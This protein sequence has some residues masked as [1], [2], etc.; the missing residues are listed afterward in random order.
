MCQINTIIGGIYFGVVRWPLIIVNIRLT[1]FGTLH[2]SQKTLFVMQQNDRTTTCTGCTEKV[3]AHER[4]IVFFFS[5]NLEYA[6]LLMI[7]LRVRSVKRY[8]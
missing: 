4:D 7:I 6:Q 1:T 8:N 3:F 2:N 5:G